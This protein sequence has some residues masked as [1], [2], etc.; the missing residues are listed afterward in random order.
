MSDIQLIQGDCLEEM[1]NIP[2]G[3]V[4]LIVS[5]LPYGTIKGLGGNLEKYK[6]LSNSDWDCI[7]SIDSLF[8][9][10]E[11]ILR[12]NGKMV[13]FAQQPFTTKLISKAL[14]NLPYS[15]TMFWDKLHFANCLTA[16]KAC[17]NY[18]EE[19]LLFSKNHDTN[20]LHP[21]RDYFKEVL[22][23]VG[24][25]KKEI[26]NQIGQK[27]DHVFRVNST[28]YSL[29][30]EQTYNELINVF[31][32]DELDGFKKFEELEKIDSVFKS[33]FKSVFNLW[34]GKKY[35]SN[36]LK[37]KKDYDGYHPT[38]KPVILLEDL[39]KT[40]S[41]HGNLVVDM[42]MGSGTTGV[43]CKNLNRNFIGIELDKDY[44]E[45]AKNRIAA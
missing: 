45:I 27:A 11:R 40:F 37:Y 21:L 14:P 29:C 26:I 10:C 17:V 30:T 7:I 25:K 33:V 16:N 5:D 6:H 44:F 41:N 39:I 1:K 36:I 2:D 22:S 31:S 13:L 15:Y 19:I 24:L 28:Q 38:Q 20:G 43:A 42:T 18:V 32:I 23:F 12:K 4:D 9:Q 35:K 34:E 8:Y 3:S